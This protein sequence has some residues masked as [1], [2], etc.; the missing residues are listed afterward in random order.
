MKAMGYGGITNRGP[1][2][3][4]NFRNPIYVG[5]AII[6]FTAIFFFLHERQPSRATDLFLGKW[7]EPNGEP[8]NYIRFYFKKIDLPNNPVPVME[9]YEGRAVFHK[10]L[11]QDEATVIYNYESFE[12]LRLNVIVPG[13]CS[14]ASIGF[15]DADHMIIRFTKTIAEAAAD[16]VFDA[17][18]VKT[19]VRVRESE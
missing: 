10:Q 15:V 19:M 18:D 2:V 17:P 11:G 7:T 6:A 12:P 4:G 14:F 13:K 5:V 9:A 1:V 8:D 3:D 16:D